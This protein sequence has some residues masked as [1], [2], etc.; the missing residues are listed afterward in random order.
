MGSI[1]GMQGGKNLEIRRKHNWS[2]LVIGLFIVL[3]MVIP[4]STHADGGVIIDDIKVW[5]QIEEGEQVAVVRLSQKDTAQVDLFVSLHD[6]SS[7]SHEIR[8]FIPLGSQPIGFSIVEE[9]YAVFAANQLDALNERLQYAAWD[10]MKYQ[11]EVRDSLLWP[12]SFLAPGVGGV[13]AVLSLSVPQTLFDNIVGGKTAE[14]IAPVK[15]L[16]TEHSHVKVYELEDD[17]NL[18][19]LVATTGLH[20]TVQDT[21]RRY[22]GQQ[23]AVITLRTQPGRSQGLRLSWASPLTGD[24]G[25]TYTY[26]LGTGSAWA[27]PIKLTSI[28]V[29]SPPG[30]DFRVAHPR[31]G[32]NRSGYIQIGSVPTIAGSAPRFSPRIMKHIDAPNY[33]VEEAWSAQEGSVWRVTYTQSNAAEDII[34]TRIAGSRPGLRSSFRELAR[35]DTGMIGLLAAIAIWIITWSLVMPHRLGFSFQWA[36][37]IIW[38]CI[39]N[40]VGALAIMMTI[41]MCGLGVVLLMEALPTPAGIVAIYLPAGIANSYLSSRAWKI[42][43]GKVA[44]AYTILVVTSGVAYGLFALTYLVLVGGL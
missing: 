32:K 7:A 15:T 21:L 30:V 39:Y 44:K 8:Y 27:R 34:I 36:R 16:Q 40:V 18:E 35:Q 43:W 31:L 1:L 11:K 20:P 2:R 41:T 17:T 5:E 10:T 42:P 22:E 38:T 13:L 25:A 4:T 26:P 6:T 14:T 9:S 33:A 29:V 28:Y 3:T 12:A 19:A 37:V 24:K 23:I